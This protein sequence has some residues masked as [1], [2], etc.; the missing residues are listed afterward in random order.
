MIS[1]KPFVVKAFVNT[2][3]RGLIGHFKDLLNGGNAFASF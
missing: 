1:N 3:S 2:F